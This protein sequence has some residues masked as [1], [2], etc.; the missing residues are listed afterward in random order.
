MSLSNSRKSVMSLTTL[1]MLLAG[2]FLSPQLQ[3]DYLSDLESEAKILDDPT[4][5]ATEEKASG[6]S[7]K[8]LEISDTL[9]PNLKQP[10]FEQQL[11]NSFL[12]SYTVYSRLTDAQKGLVY[13]SYTDNVGID[14]LKRLI[15]ELYNKL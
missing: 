10:E 8:E 14:E 4:S 7:I 12:G 13:A 5:T 11:K 2:L 9:T 1:V 6:W 15:R 3:A